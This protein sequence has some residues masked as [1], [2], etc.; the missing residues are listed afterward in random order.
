MSAN[1]TCARGRFG[2][3]CIRR[4]RLCLAF[5]G[6][7]RKRCKEEWRQLAGCMA[8][9]SYRH[10]QML[11][12]HYYEE[13]SAEE[14]AAVLGISPGAVYTRLHRAREKLKKLLLK[15]GEPWT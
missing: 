13:L 9:L 7:K 4:N 8:K 10:R 6:W 3:C 14:I 15:E 5:P 12:L 2:I 11:V 1:A